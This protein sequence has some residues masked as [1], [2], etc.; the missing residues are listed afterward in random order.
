MLIVE[1]FFKEI[2]C[3]V[4]W[5]FG[6]DGEWNWW[7]AGWGLFEEV[8]ETDSF[9]HATEQILLWAVEGDIWAFFIAITVEV[10]YGG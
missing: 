10:C 1:I 8:C 2:W 6:E 9:E 5:A 4:E 3:V 7:D